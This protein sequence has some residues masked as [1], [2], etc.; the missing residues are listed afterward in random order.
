MRREWK[1][2]LLAVAILAGGVG[3]AL[4]DFAYTADGTASLSAGESLGWR[5]F[6]NEPIAITALGLYDD[7]EPGLAGP[8]VLGIWRLPRGERA[9]LEQWISIDGNGDFQADHHVYVNLDDPFI[10]PPC[11]V[12][13]SD[14]TAYDERWMVGVWSPVGSTD[15][16][17]LPGAAV[18]RLIEEAGIIQWQANTYKSW[19]EDFNPTLGRIEEGPNWIPWPENTG[20]TDYYGVTFQYTV[21]PVPGAVL[22]GVMGLSSAGWLLRRKT[23]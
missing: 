4:G 18:T 20:N 2:G 10:I 23:A 6:V 9:R 1:A 21:I 13:P 17:I 11:P 7:G 8:H 19:T 14:R 3:P 22:L 15:G 12:P 16:L 5:F